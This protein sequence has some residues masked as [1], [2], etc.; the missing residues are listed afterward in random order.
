M[1]AKDQGTALGEWVRT[2]ELSLGAVGLA[3]SVIG[4]ALSLGRPRALSPHS[5]GLLLHGA[6]SGR[7]DMVLALGLLLLL[8]TPVLGVLTAAV[9]GF[10]HR[11]PRTAIVAT[12]AMLIIVMGTLVR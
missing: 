10:V 5:L 2:A 4:I 7:A 11:Q 9:Y 1:S 8:L 3:L 6:F 12:L